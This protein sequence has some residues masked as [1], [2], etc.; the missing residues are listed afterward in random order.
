MPINVYEGVKLAGKAFVVEETI[1]RNCTLTNCWLYYSGGSYEWQNT[2]FQNCQWGFR[3]PA[4]DTIA[5]LQLLGLM[6]AGQTPPPNIHID[7]TKVN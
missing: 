7:A 4:K 5:L 3:G 1:F 6:T 2:S